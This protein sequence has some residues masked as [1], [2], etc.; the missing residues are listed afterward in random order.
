MFNFVFIDANRHKQKIQCDHIIKELLDRFK[1]EDESV[2]Q[3]S[4]VL[5]VGKGIEERMVGAAL[6]QSVSLSHIQEDVRELVTDL[7]L[8]DKIWLCSSIIFE[9]SEY[10]VHFEKMQLD[11]FSRSFCRDLYKAFV[12][13]GYLKGINFMIMKLTPHVYLFTKEYGLWPYV[14]ELRPHHSSDKLFHGILPLKGTQSLAYQKNSEG[15]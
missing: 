10:E 3:T 7:P 15:V 5:I 8:Q 13:F 4:H 14:V 6:I 12:E 1:Q 9:P 11:Y 2:L